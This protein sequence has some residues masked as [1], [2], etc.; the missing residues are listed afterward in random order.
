MNQKDNDGKRM[1]WKLQENKIRSEDKTEKSH[2]HYICMTIGCDV[3]WKKGNPPEPSMVK[4][5]N[6]VMRT[7]D[8]FVHVNESLAPGAAAH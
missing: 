6:L 7:G 5:L 2:N 1:N 4:Q 8:L 3:W